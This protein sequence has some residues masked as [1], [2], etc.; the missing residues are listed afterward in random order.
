MTASHD[1]EDLMKY[2]PNCGCILDEEAD[3]LTMHAR[4]EAEANLLDDAL[5]AHLKATKGRNPWNTQ[6][7]W[8]TAAQ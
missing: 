7:C 2:C 3:P 6:G 8:P 1:T 5:S 4:I